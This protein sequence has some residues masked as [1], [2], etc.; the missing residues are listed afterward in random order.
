MQMDL[1]EFVESAPG[2][3]MG[4]LLRRFWQPV[5]VASAVGP[6]QTMA[7][8]ILNEDL[9]LYR[10]E[11]GQ[12]HLVGQRC[13]HRGTELRVGWVEG[14][15]LRCFYHGWKYDHT[16][17]CVEQ[18]AEDESFARKVKI[19]GYPVQEYAGLLLAYLGEGEPPPLPHRAELERGYG[20]QWLVRQVWPCNWFQRIENSMDGAHV[21]FV[22]REAPFGQAVTPVIPK[23]EYEE[24]E[25][26]IIQRAVR[27][28][29]NVRV[30]EFHFP[31]CNHI[32]VPRAGDDGNGVWAD[33][34]AWKV[35][36]DDE[37]TMEFLVSDVPVTG[38]AEKR[39]RE[40]AVEY[41][42]YDPS[43]HHEELL[44]GIMPKDP[45]RLIAAQDY[46]AQV[47]QG[48]IAD[49]GSERLGKCDAGLIF[50]RK[51]FRR[52]LDAI[53]QGQ[54]GKQWQH[55][56]GLAQLPMPPAVRQPVAS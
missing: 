37:H 46:L 27:G 49:R 26:G 30:S 53:N 31:N 5:A 34:F 24:T 1:H 23:L 48:G 41:A 13:A 29:D 42:Q 54:P 20:V 52:E 17:Q 47:L 55:R 12:A 38:E 35:P 6:G 44:R 2:T 11:T 50:L 51:I 56:T 3:P 16:G 7:V 14:D 4:K 28:P 9:T 25:W 22:H 39:L 18:P 8:R 45:T 19:A 33:L 15:C 43:E 10:G 36:V 21:S 32:V 40:W